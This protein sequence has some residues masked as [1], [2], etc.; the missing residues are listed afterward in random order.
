MARDSEMAGG[1]GMVLCYQPLE[2][3]AK[4]RE[5]HR[6][7]RAR[8]DGAAVHFSGKRG[9]FNR[10]MQHKLKVCL[11][12][13]NSQK[14][15]ATFDSNATPSWLESYRVQPDRSVLLEKYRWIN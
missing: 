13:W 10:S 1:E 3:A 7:Q 11:Q 6:S 2:A 8:G 9:G 5:I 12:A 14:A 4:R 15:F